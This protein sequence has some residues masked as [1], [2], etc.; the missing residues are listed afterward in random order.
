MVKEP[1]SDTLT[2][3]GGFAPLAGHLIL[4]LQMQK[5]PA[6]PSKVSLSSDF[7][8]PPQKAHGAPQTL[9]WENNLNRRGPVQSSWQ[10]GNAT[11][12]VPS[13]LQAR[14]I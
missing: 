7:Q 8:V 13:P 9:L 1:K 12:D 3:V 6:G 11:L 5:C 10:L 2:L 14:W 4:Q